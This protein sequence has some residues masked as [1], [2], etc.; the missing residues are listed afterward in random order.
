MPYPKPTTSMTKE[1]II[2]LLNFIIRKC[3]CVIN[4]KN[5]TADDFVQ[6][7]VEDI[8]EM[9]HR[10]LDGQFGEILEPNAAAEKEKLI[11]KACNWLENYAGNFLSGEYNEF[12]HQIEYDGYDTERMVKQFRISMEK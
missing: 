3:D 10:V 6:D 12:H 5:Y 8:A 2:N 9:C 11:E 7:K 1:E 4:N